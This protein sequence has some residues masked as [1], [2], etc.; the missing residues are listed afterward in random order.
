MQAT[1]TG[2]DQYIA[3]PVI[4]R[5]TQTT[6]ASVSEAELTAKL[7]ALN[8]TVNQELYG[9]TGAPS[10]TPATGGLFNEI[11]LSNSINNLS[12]VTITNSS[13]SGGSGGGGG[14]GSGTVDSGTQGQFAFYNAPGTTI[15]ATSSLFLA[16]SGSVGIGTTSSISQLAIDSSDPNGSFLTLSNQSDGSFDAIHFISKNSDSTANDWLVGTNIDDNNIFEIAPGDT[17][18]GADTFIVDSNGNV[19]IGTT[20]PYATL[21]VAGSAAFSG[22]TSIGSDGLL[23]VGVAEDPDGYAY[24]N[25]LNVV[26]YSTSTDPN[27]MNLDLF[28]TIVTPTSD[29]TASEIDPNNFDLELNGSDDYTWGGDTLSATA[30]M[31]G[32]GTADQ[33]NGVGGFANVNSGSI[34][35]TNDQGAFGVYGDGQMYG[36]SNVSQIA[37]VL[38]EA[39]L[40]GGTAQDAAALSGEFYDQGATVT[41]G[42]GLK[43]YVSDEAGTIYNDYGVYVGSPPS[44]AG[45][46]GNNYGIWIGDQSNVGTTS[47]YA[48]WYDSPGVFRIKSDGVMAYYNPSFSPKYTPNATNFERVVQEWSNNTAEYGTENEGTGQ[49]VP[50]AF[51]TASTTRMTIGA[52]GNVGVGTSSL[53]SRLTVWGPDAATTSAFAVV[54]AASTTVFAIYDSGN[55]TYSG[56]IFQS[57]DQRL[58]TDIES[59]DAS[60]SLSAVEALNAVSYLR[61]DQPGQG[62][63]LGFLAQQVAQVFPQLVSTTSATALTPDGTLTLNYQ[64]L[65]API[66]AAIQELDQQLT[67]LANTVAGFAQ[68]FVSS[69]ITATNQLCVGTTCVSQQQFAA[70]VAAAGRTTETIDGAAEPMSGSQATDTPP[71]IEVNGDDPAVVQ[72]GTTYDDLGAHIT[73][74]QNDLNLGIQSFVNGSPMS[75]VQIDTSAAA[76]DTIDYVVTDQNGLTATSTRTVIIEIASSTAA[77]STT[78]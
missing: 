56:S 51:I 44:N 15:T 9:S 34:T 65:I 4:E 54:N 59:L 67:N 75:P 60:S 46:I 12:G 27:D 31:N 17:N 32:S 45:G 74:P 66:V 49:A 42:Y 57:S 20:S 39:A 53:S 36:G 30:N 68:S 55:S 24:A 13:V 10:S 19:G 64:G 76:T 72:V 5:I 2:V 6:Q 28:A 63:N 3:Q 69:D 62:E 58:K 50:L 37:G 41:N 14:G 78:D 40:Y 77:T 26:Q 1:T 18:T 70:M 8:N 47:N 35:G 21:S 48:F 23:N 43:T 38:G 22:G 73:G 29:V 52:T 11:A 61:L 33:I 16:Q 25:K 7:A 71:V